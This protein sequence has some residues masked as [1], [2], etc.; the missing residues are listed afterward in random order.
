MNSLTQQ[1]KK[2]IYLFW[3]ALVIYLGI[4]LIALEQFPIYFFSDEA[5][6]TVRAADFLRDGLHSESGELLP[7]F[8]KNSYQYNLG[9]S[10]YLQIIPTLLLG[11]HIV[12]TRAVSVIVSMLAAISA[13]LTIEL[14]FKRHAGW[15]AIL[16]LS[17]MPAW[18]L[19]SRTAFET[20][21]AVSFYCA[22]WLSYALYRFRDRR[23]IYLAAIFAALAFYSYS[24]AQVV[25][26]L[27]IVA[28]FFNDI[29]FHWQNRKQLLKVG[30]LAVVL[31]LP[32]LRFIWLHPGEFSNHLQL[33]GSVWVSDLSIWQKLITILQEYFRGLNPFYWFFSNSVDL[34]RHVMKGY[35]HLWQ[36]ALPLMAVG[37]I[38]CLLHLRSSRHRLILIAMFCAPAGAAMAQLGITRALFMVFSAALLSTI[39][40]IILWDWL[41]HQKPLGLKGSKP[42]LLITLAL[43]AAL[44][45]VNIAMLIDSLEN[46]PTWFDN[47]GLYGMQYGAR[48]VFHEIKNDLAANPQENIVLSPAWANGTDILARYFFDDPLPFSLA[49]IASYIEN[50][51][52]LDENT[53][54]ILLPNEMEDIIASK[55]FQNVRTLKTLPYP[56]GEPGFY[57]IH[58]N[59]VQGIQDIFASEKVA[60][61]K[62]I[63]TNTHLQDGTEISAQYSPLDI[64]SI[65]DL[66]DDDPQTLARSWESNPF[67]LMVEFAKPRDADQLMVR[68]GGEPTRIELELTTAMDAPPLHFGLSEPESA[69]PRDLTIHLNLTQPIIKAIVRVYNEN[70]QEPAHVHLWEIRFLPDPE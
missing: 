28:F 62:L 47:Y 21:I 3:L 66:F 68:V 61:H 25:V 18:F 64:G 10:V 29:R 51:Q 20:A 67:V 5:V 60:R 1:K 27:T 43:F 56:N 23:Y 49:S 59:Y 19:H 58:L 70:E 46:G 2:T 63:D 42:R 48:Q 38:Y 31:I 53:T 4:R 16:L 22:F 30:V 45:Q 34:P 37:L 6:Q 36:P 35:G 13:G 50:Y 17:A 39:G 69:H 32:Y 40:A 7:A 65:D 8:F 26:S 44:S 14:I 15:L 57:F 52:P 9:V 33:V 54:L 41:M 11:K 12:V 55:K 24:P